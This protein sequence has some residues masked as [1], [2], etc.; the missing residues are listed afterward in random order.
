MTETTITAENTRELV[1]LRHPRDFLETLPDAYGLTGMEAMAGDSCCDYCSI[2]R[3]FCICQG[4]EIECIELI[5]HI[6]FG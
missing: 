6:I 3:D 2:C 5:L 4:F 1:W